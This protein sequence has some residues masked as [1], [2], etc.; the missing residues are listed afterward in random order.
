MLES[1]GYSAEYLFGAGY[2]VDTLRQFGFSNEVL[3]A[4]PVA[5]ALYGPYGGP[6]V[7]MLERITRPSFRLKYTFPFI[8]L[9]QKKKIKHKMIPMSC[10]PH[11][12]YEC[13]RVGEVWLLGR[14][15]AEYRIPP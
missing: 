7:G 8:F 11:L 13:R 10:R 2:T 6:D 3:S 9:N 15:P 12:E 4:L 14:L 1:Q 5:R